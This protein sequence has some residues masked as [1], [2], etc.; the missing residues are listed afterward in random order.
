M[1][2]GG[3]LAR[4]RQSLSEHLRMMMK[5][6]LLSSYSRCIWRTAVLGL[7]TT[8]PMAAADSPN[9]RLTPVDVLAVMHRVADWQ[10]AHPSAHSA[11][12]WT[13]A[14]GDAGMMAL[15]GISGDP[16]YRD[17]LLAMSEANGWKPGPRMYHADDLAIGQTFAGLYLLYR[18]PKMIAPLRSRLE[19]ILSAPPEVESLDFHQPSDQVAQI[20][21]LSD[22]LFM[23]PSVWIHLLAPTAEARSLEFAVH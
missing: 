13:Q 18:D 20:W 14:A 6:L 12:D 2:G 9:W 17:A 22:S 8:L 15:A 7:A 23:A 11:T 1:V 19:A 3:G 10:L 5:A 4:I 21:S 16:K